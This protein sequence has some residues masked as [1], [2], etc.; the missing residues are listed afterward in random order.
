M[1]FAG[2]V[3][4]LMDRSK[5]TGVRF[6]PTVEAL[7]GA[8]EDE[9]LLDLGRP[10]ALEAVTGLVAGGKRVVGFVSHVD[11][12]TIEAATAAGCEALPRSELF[13]RWQQIAAG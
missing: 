5:L 8:A 3:P 12:A 13:R 4:D 1:S 9:V 7:R 2:F 11:R 6:V 10:G